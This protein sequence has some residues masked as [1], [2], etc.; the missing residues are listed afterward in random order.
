MSGE[1][2]TRARRRAIHLP[3]STDPASAG[4]T[5]QPVLPKGVTVFDQRRLR[6]ALRLGLV[7][8]IAPLEH[9]S[10]ELLIATVV[11]HGMPRW[12]ADQMRYNPM[13]RLCY[14]KFWCDVGAAATGDP[15]AK[16]KVDAAREAW[17][18]MRQIE[19]IANR[20]GHTIG[21]WER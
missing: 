4:S 21:F 20:P 6:Q 19:L 5:R 7:D 10:D 14:L 2:D 11:N 13:L 1:Q 17:S 8:G 15:E 16:E 3:Y 18:K 12:S 9:P